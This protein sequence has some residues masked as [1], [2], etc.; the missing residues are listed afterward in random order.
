MELIIEGKRAALKPGSSF[1]YVSENRAFSDADDYTLSITLPLAGCPENLEIFGRLDR[2]DSDSRAVIM[3]ASI[4][5]HTFTRNG[6]V[7]VVDANEKE[8]KCQFLEGRSVQNFDSTFDDRY[9]NELPLGVY[10]MESLPRVIEYKNIDQGAYCVPLPWVNDSADG[11]LNNEVLVE[12]GAYK[13]ADTTEQ[14]GKLSYMPYLI[15]IAKKICNAVGYTCDF[16]EWE[17]SDER[18]LLVCNVLP[19]SWDINSFARALPHWTVAEFFDE[20]EKILVCEIN[21]DHRTRHI[22]MTF[23]RNVENV[24]NVVKIDDVLDSFTSE[25]AYGED[26]CEFKGAANIRYADRG[27]EDWKREQ[28]QWL[29]DLMKTDKKH[30]R[31]FATYSDYYS[32]TRNELPLFR[33]NDSP[34]AP[35]AN[36]LAYIKELDRYVIWKSVP[37]PPG[38]EYKNGYSYQA[39]WINRFGDLVRDP[40]SDNDIELKMVPARVTFLDFEHSYAVFLAPS[41][42]SEDEETDGDGTRQPIPFSNF[43]KGEPD[44]AAEYYDKIYLAYYGLKKDVDES[45]PWSVGVPFPTVDERF[46]L[47]RRY[48][49]YLAGLTINSKE[50]VKI[51]WLD[52]AIP[53]V[54]SMFHIRG[55]RYLC[56][57][58][59]ATFSENGMSQLLK[60]EFYPLVS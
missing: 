25:I 31:E 21:I 39:V 29:I 9:I 32:A 4:V 2:M 60:G 5:Y 38:G 28:C 16:S 33:T 24:S 23:S 30:Y 36:C 34:H 44:S 14:I 57:K 37:P 10:P 58:I 6:V 40:D 26:M 27:D 22:G 35:L 48:S 53:D 1:D 8:L 41:G 51:S 11:F 56:E 43:S 55:K 13:W 15:Y 20:L 47:K 17:Q 42:Y 46:S 19:A 45:L 54:R 49:E 3:E 52:S 50:K 18:F 12:D 59:T 7:T